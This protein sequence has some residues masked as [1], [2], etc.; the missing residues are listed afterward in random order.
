MSHFR[1]Y[2]ETKKGSGIDAEG[3]EFGDD[4]PVV[5]IL[6]PDGRKMWVTTNNVPVSGYDQVVPTP[7]EMGAVI[8]QALEMNC[9]GLFSPGQKENLAT[10]TKLSIELDK[11]QQ[12]LSQTRRQLKRVKLELNGQQT[13]F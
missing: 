8:L 11:T 5:E 4:W 9:R 10:I 2:V 6:R 7:D 13:L 12:A 3:R 1:I